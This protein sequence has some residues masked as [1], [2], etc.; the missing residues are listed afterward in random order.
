MAEHNDLGKKGETKAVQFLLQKGA[1]ILEQNWRFGKDEIDLIATINNLLVFVEVKTR[2]NAYFGSP[3]EFVSLQK[4]KRIVKAANH[5]V[6]K[7]NIDL[8]VRFDIIGIILN[9]NTLQIEHI[10]DAFT[11]SWY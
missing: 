6:E 9:N 2:H 3:H 7:K 8:E 1:I 4:Q 10:E 11:P 5:Y